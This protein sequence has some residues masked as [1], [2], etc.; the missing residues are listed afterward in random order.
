MVPGKVVDTKS[1]RVSTGVD[2][3]G[4]ARG[5]RFAL[6]HDEKT[7]GGGEAAFPALHA[8]DSTMEQIAVALGGAIERERR[9]PFA[10]TGRADMMV[11]CFPG[12]GA[13]Y[14]MH[15]DAHLHG[16]SHSGQDPR[17]LTSILYINREWEEEH[18][19]ALCMHDATHAC[20]RT[21]LP[22]AD[23]LVLF[24]SDQVLHR[25]AR[26]FEWRLALTVFLLGEYRDGSEPARERRARPDL[27][28]WR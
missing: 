8:L 22:R 9:L 1:G 14:G 12:G 4:V 20:W 7:F 15:L 26:A 21:V 28:Q 2:P 17:K 27:E 3:L 19:G 16:G 23:T 11:A 18:G 24:R 25:V 6:L 13:E 5:D 10:L